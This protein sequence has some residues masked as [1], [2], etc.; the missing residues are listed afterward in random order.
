M[1]GERVLVSFCMTAGAGAGRIL[2][3]FTYVRMTREDFPIQCLC[4]KLSGKTDFVSHA[5]LFI[6]EI[7]MQ[8]EPEVQFLLL[9][10]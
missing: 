2:V 10:D 8:S 1:S 9:P 7:C 4:F 5:A 6:K 3:I